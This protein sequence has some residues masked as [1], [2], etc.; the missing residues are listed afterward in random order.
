MYDQ[1]L[2]ILHSILKNLTDK[3]IALVRSR[4]HQH[5]ESACILT[6]LTHLTLELQKHLLK[7]LQTINSLNQLNQLREWIDTWGQRMKW[8]GSRADKELDQHRGQTSRL[9]TLSYQS[10]LTIRFGWDR[11]RNQRPVRHVLSLIGTIQFC[12][13]LS[14]LLII[15]LFMIQ[16]SNSLQLCRRD[17]Q[18]W[19]MWHLTFSIR[20][21]HLEECISSRMPKKDG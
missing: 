18:S 19:M 7:L 1:C 20:Q 5:Q 15:T 3:T 16:I 4:G 6:N 9:E 14:W 12:V 11:A 13:Q 17:L 21:R 8:R 10:W 2:P